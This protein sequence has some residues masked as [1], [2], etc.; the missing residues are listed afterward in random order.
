MPAS[1]RSAIVTPVAVSDPLFVATIIHVMFPASSTCDAG[2]ATFVTARSL[3]GA[4]TS[5]SSLHALV[6]P[7]L[8]ESLSMRLLIVDTRL[9]NV[10]LFDFGTAPF[11]TVTAPGIG[12]TL[13]VQPLS[14][15]TLS[16]TVPPASAVAPLSTAES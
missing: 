14:L 3:S 2:A 15:S 12:P 5:Y 8:F 9:L 1:I 4:L 10:T 11:V 7:L 6:E 13:L 16:V